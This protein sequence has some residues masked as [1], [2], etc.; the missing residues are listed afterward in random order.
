V[1][2]R[3]QDKKAQFYVLQNKQDRLCEMRKLPQMK[4]SHKHI[5][6]YSEFVDGSRFPDKDKEKKDSALDID[7]KV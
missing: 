6:V 7:C 5:V 2:Q 1:V 3:L 4:E